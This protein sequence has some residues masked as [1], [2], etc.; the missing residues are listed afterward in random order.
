MTKAV[1]SSQFS[2]LISVLSSQLSV[3]S[4]WQ[5]LLVLQKFFVYRK[6]DNGDLSLKL[7][8]EN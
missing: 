6:T 2:V 4:C 7:G 1:L 8:T 3:L 5:P